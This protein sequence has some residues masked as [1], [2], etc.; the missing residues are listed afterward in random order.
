MLIAPKFELEEIGTPLKLKW[1]NKCTL[2]TISY[3]HGISVTPLQVATTYASL[4]NGGNLINPTILIN[5]T[6]ILKKRIIS[7]KTSGELNSILRKVVTDKNGTA[8]LADIY[9]YSVGGKTGTSQNYSNKK[10]NINTFISIFPTEK[11]KYVFLVMLEN[12]KPAPNLV[13]EYRGKKT[14]VNRNEAGW[15]SVY[16]AGKIIK[17]IGPILAINNKEFN[18]NYVA[19]I[20]E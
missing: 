15:N 7:S 2:E 17:K 10:D 19:K 11:P 3:G 8:S 13:Y 14:K 16:V 12:P 1:K 18:N 20:S 5:N 6:K 9:G 4:T